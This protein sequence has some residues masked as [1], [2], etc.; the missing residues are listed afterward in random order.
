VPDSTI[1][2]IPGATFDMWRMKIAMHILKLQ[3]ALEK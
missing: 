1:N 3:A 2:A